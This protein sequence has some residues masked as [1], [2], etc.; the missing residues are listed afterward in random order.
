MIRLFKKTD[1]NQ[2]INIW[3]DASIKAHSFINEEFWRS[4]AKE[5]RE[6]Y[7]PSGETYVFE[8][9]HIVKGFMSLKKD[10]LAAIFV[11]PNEQRKG[12]GKK[13]ILK[14]KQLRK[15]LN[16]TVYKENTDSVEFYKKSGFKIIDEQK[17]LHTGH[18]E[19]IMQYRS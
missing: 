13:L 12:I 4:K 1:M 7:I 15:N 5:M 11:S 9:E 10:T 19:L 17:D 2:V 18:L 14:A 6:I 3:L 16:L 8:E